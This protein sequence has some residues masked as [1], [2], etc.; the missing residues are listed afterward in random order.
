[1][2]GWWRVII[3]REGLLGVIHNASEKT[4]GSDDK[5]SKYSPDDRS[6][7]FK[8]LR[9]T[10]PAALWPCKRLRKK[11]QAQLCETICTLCLGWE[12]YIPQ[13]QTHKAWPRM[14]QFDSHEPNCW[15]G[16]RCD[17]DDPRPRSKRLRV[18][19]SLPLSWFDLDF[20]NCLHIRK[21]TLVDCTWFYWMPHISKRSDVWYVVRSCWL[22]GINSAVNRRNINLQF[23]SGKV[24]QYI[25]SGL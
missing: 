3:R 12:I 11:F 18:K 1:M 13:G 6:Y 25:V 16:M 10:V 15:S 22:Y 20:C 14:M 24:F 8:R 7:A 21:T 9:V 5:P 2:Q 4:V 17:S 23:T 19:I